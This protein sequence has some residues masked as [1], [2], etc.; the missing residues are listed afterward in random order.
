MPAP[1]SAPLNA[2]PAVPEERKQQ[3]LPPKSYAD[4]VEEEPPVNGNSSVNGANG[5][6]GTDGSKQ[7]NG[8]T[9][10]AV[11]QSE[12]PKNAAS[13]L[14]IVDTGV[15]VKEEPPTARPAVERKQS[16]QEFTATVSGAID[17]SRYKIH[18]LTT[19]RGL[20]TL[21]ELLHDKSTAS[22][23]LP[24]QVDQKRRRDT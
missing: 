1:N 4:A 14:R 17:T 15:P 24:V 5:A 12:L 11:G 9:G 22:P 7:T 8:A 19:G 23:H 18:I 2:E 16:Q 21:R 10:G 13:V 20:T 3:Q 6:N